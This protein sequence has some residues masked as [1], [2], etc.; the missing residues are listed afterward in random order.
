[1]PASPVP[2]TVCVALL[3]S[4]PALV[5]ATPGATVSS[6]KP[7]APLVPAFP[8]ASVSTAVRLCAPWPASV[9]SSDQCPVP[10]TVV[11]P[12]VAPLSF[13]T[14][15]VPASPVPVMVCAGTLVSPPAL[16]IAGVGARVSSVMVMLLLVPT[17][18]AASVSRAMMVCAPSLS[19][20][21]ATPQPWP[22]PLPN[23]VVLPTEPPSTSTVS[24]PPPSP[25]PARLTRLWLVRPPALVMVTVGVMVSTTKLLPM[26]AVPTLPAASVSRT[27]MLCWPSL[28][29]TVWLQRPLLAVVVPSTTEPVCTSSSCTVVPLSPWP[30]K[31]M[32]AWL[33]T[34]ENRLTLALM[35]TTGR[36]WSSV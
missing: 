23:S 22:W 6:V 24:E 35:S 11:L 9:T 3:V 16:P 20:L 27:A 29:V 7:T 12:R 5:M 31:V 8:A 32:L 25:V 17:L 18:P 36:V 2:V 30:L 14:S 34:W 33:V 15:V 13:T 28:S 1:M 4:P 10:S 21:N 19:R 26:L